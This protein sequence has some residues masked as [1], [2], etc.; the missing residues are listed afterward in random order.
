MDGRPGAT[1]RDVMT[2][3]VTTITAGT[4]LKEAAMRL[5]SGGFSALPVVDDGGRVIGVLSEADLLVKVERPVPAPVGHPSHGQRERHA[6][7]TGTVASN[8]M[9]QPAVTV[10]P[11]AGLASAARLMLRHGLKRL[12]VVDDAGRPAGIVS[13]GDLLSVFL[14]GDEEVHRDVLERLEAE[15]P[16]AALAPVTV[17]VDDGLVS[18]SGGEVEQ[19]QARRMVRLA[20]RT[21]G[22]V[23]VRSLLRTTSAAP[24]RSGGGG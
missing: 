23:A 18:L 6:R 19:D 17:A 15:L 24:E 21:D 22:V 11:D 8:L 14:R 12:P 9:S 4:R 7:W 5:Q 13:R 10:G 1:V 16:A 20:E 2:S 3:P